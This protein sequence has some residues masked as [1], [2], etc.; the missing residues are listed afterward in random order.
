[1]AAGVMGS[2]QQADNLSKRS[3]FR[4]DFERNPKGLGREACMQLNGIGSGHGTESHHVTNCIHSHGTREKTGG[5]GASGALQDASAGLK[6]EIRQQEQFSLTDWLQR[7]VTGGKRLWRNIW[8]STEAGQSQTGEKETGDRRAFET[9]SGLQ[10]G[11]GNRS[12]SSAS[13]VSAVPTAAAEAAA[14]AHAQDLQHNPYFSLQEK[15]GETQGNVWQKIRVKLKEGAG[16]LTGHL[17]GFLNLRNGNSFQTKK[18]QPREDLRKKSRFKRD[19]VEIDCVLTD[20]SYLLDS[21]DRKG[22]YSRLSAVKDNQNAAV[23]DSQKSLT[24]GE[25]L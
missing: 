11:T 10:Q 14:S 17:P 1:M 9:A 2:R 5:A 4:T 15:A 23:K 18:E 25:N 16:Q 22:E 21:Y 8:G 19:Q 3:L 12:G 24:K 7:T 6:T 13:T 20:D